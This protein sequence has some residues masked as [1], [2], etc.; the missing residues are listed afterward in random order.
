M[1]PDSVLADP[2]HYCVELENERV[3]VL[4]VSYGPHEKSVLHSHN[5]GFAV[6]L[7]D[8]DFRFYLPEGKTQDIIGKVGQ[9]IEFDKPFEHL[10]ENRSARPFE[11]VFVE[12][13]S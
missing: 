10:P 2:K 13:K 1:T 11:A 3:R 5:A 4:R 6:L 8:C 9:L 7:S 12:L